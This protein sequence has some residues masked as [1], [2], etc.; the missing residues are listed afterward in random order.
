MVFVDSF[1]NGVANALGFLVVF[2]PV[3]IALAAMGLKFWPRLF[4]KLMNGLSPIMALMMG[5]SQQMGPPLPPLAPEAPEAPSYLCSECG[6]SMMKPFSYCPNC[7]VSAVES[8]EE[9]EPI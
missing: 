9:E 8:R 6:Y 2:I 1:V 3:F 7:G 4:G 5:S